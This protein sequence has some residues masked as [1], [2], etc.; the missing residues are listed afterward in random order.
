MAV[1]ATGTVVLAGATVTSLATWLDEE[2]VIAG[3]NGVGGIGSSEFEIEQLVASDDPDTGW[4]NRETQPEAGVISLDDV[5]ANL[6]PGAVA[7]GWVQLRAAEGSVGGDVTL[8]SDYA[9]SALGAVLVYGARVHPSTATC[10]SDDYASTGTELVAPTTS[11]SLGSGTTSFALTAGTADAPGMPRT[12]CFRVE[13]PEA[14]ADDDLQ[15]EL[16]SL[17]WH[18]VAESD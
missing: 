1:I 8:A 5:A 9:P 17:G 16:A 4:A 6:S 15:G 10:N 7:Y 11:V 2:W 14:A 18:F 3:V 13:F 12:V